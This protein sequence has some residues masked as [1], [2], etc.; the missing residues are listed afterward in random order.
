MS[1]MRLGVRLWRERGTKGVRVPLW[2]WGQCPPKSDTNPLTLPEHPCYYPHRSN[3]NPTISR[4]NHN[5][6]GTPALAPEDSTS[7]PIPKGGPHAAPRLKRKPP[8]PHTK[9]PGSPFPATQAM[10]C[11]QTIL[12]RPRP[13]TPLP[14]QRPPSSGAFTPA[15][16][17]P[18]FPVGQPTPGLARPSCPCLSRRPCHPSTRRMHRDAGYERP[19]Q[20][21]SSTSAVRSCAAHELGSAPHNPDHS[22]QRVGIIQPGADGSAATPGLVSSH[23]PSIAC[24]LPNKSSKTQPQL[25]NPS[26]ALTPDQPRCYPLR[27]HK[28]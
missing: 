18:V 25:N 23:G 26:P 12:G 7:K 6:G 1:K 14:I 27:R 9:G 16:C 13:T 17:A 2:G 20:A 15:H 24:P 28:P 10:E 21:A 3:T 5:T 19:P 11:P 22:R 8:S 4:R